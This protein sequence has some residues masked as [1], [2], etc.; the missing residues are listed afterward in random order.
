MSGEHRGFGINLGLLTLC[1]ALVSTCNLLIVSVAILS[2]H[3]I[4]DNKALAALPVALQWFGTAAMAGPASFF[5]QRLGRKAGFW[6]SAGT[7][8]TGAALSVWALYEAH[9]GLLCAGGALIGVG[10]G[11]SWYYRFAAAEMVP[12]DFRSRAISLLLAGGIVAA[13]IGPTLADVSKDVLSPV[14]Y[15]GTYAAIMVL[16]VF[17]VTVLFFVKIPR[18]SAEALRGGRPLSVIARQPAFIV[19]V[20]AAVVAYSVMGLLMSVTPLAMV[21]H[22]HSFDQATLVIQW[23]VLGMYVPS[24][25]TGHLVRWFGTLNIMLCGALLMFG[26]LAVGLSGTTV[27]HFWIALGVLGLGWNFLFVGATTLLTETYTIAE[28]AKTQ[29]VNEVA[30]F[31][32]VGLATFFSGTLLHEFGW[33]AVNY[34]ALPALAVVTIAILLLKWRGSVTQ[35]TAPSAAGE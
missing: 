22:K 1:W 17:V 16:Y 28:R 35:S 4:A 20:I 25:F 15:A 6:A 23:H 24:F 5:M 30:I 29:A 2:G 19:A 33:S 14:S 10:N 8:S 13:L 26:C 32:I 18:P 21:L 9:F 34:S 12:D 7:V 31:T 11:F 27:A 3:A